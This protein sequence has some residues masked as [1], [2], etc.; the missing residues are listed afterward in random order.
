M[1]I[2]KQRKLD[3]MLSPIQVDEQYPQIYKLRTLERWRSIYRDSGEKI[4][5]QWIRVGIRVIKYKRI[6][7]ERDI[8]GLGWIEHTPP[9]AAKT[10]TILSYSNTTN[11]Q[12]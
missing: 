11:K 5:P 10:A 8:Q 6:W 1:S 12:Q 4:G 3:D 7:I 9:Q 2:A